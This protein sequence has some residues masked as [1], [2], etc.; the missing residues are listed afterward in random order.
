[1]LAVAANALVGLWNHARAKTVNWRC[2]YVFAGAGVIGAL[3]GST[4]GKAIDGDKLL[5][6][7]AILM[8]VVAVYMF[9]TRGD[10]GVEGAQC[11]R[12]NAAK[13]V[14][15]GLGTGVFSGFFGIGGGFLIVPGLVAATSMPVLK[16]VGTSLVAV[17]SFGFATA[18]NYAMS[19]FVIWPLAAVF[20]LGGF[21]GSALGARAARRLAAKKGTLNKIFASLVVGVAG[22]MLYEVW[23]AV[24]A[25]S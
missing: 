24:A 8:V 25:N 10:E 15:Y 23:L 12:D 19:D 22:Y 2:G 4:V 14:A 17:F 6:V 21:I 13:V 9:V 7:F 3:A 16:A 20:V 18:A 1:A 5:F 11:N